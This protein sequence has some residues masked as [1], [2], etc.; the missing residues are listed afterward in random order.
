VLPRRRAKAKREFK[1]RV[2]AMRSQL[3]Q[4]LE[5]QFR[6]Q[7]ETNRARIRETIAPYDRFVRAES[8]GLADRRAEL[9]GFADR[10]DLQRRQVEAGG[11]D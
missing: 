10:L 8:K 5:D 11:R 3:L 9:E 7:A 1:A 6:R 2:S 4:R